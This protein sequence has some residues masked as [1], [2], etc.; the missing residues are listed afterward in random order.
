MF[1]DF[2]ATTCAPC[3]ADIERTKTVREAMK[4]NREVVFLFLTSDDE[5]PKGDYDDYVAKHL[6]DEH[7][8][9]IPMSDYA[10]LRELFQ[11]NGIPHYEILSKN[12]SVIR[13]DTHYYDIDSFN[14]LLEKI[15]ENV[16]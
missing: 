15:K 13:D 14:K 9:R 7:V 1:L 6:K 3:R 2:W 8:Y 5:S 10:K 4:D 12:G 16:E 11:F